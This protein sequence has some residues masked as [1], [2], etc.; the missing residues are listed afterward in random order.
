MSRQ[1]LP[2]HGHLLHRANGHDPIPVLLHVRV[3]SDGAGVSAGD[4]KRTITIT[5]DLGGTR[6][7]SAQA[8][9]V[10]GGS[11][12]TTIQIHNVTEAVDMLADKIQIDSGDTD[13]YESVAPSVVDDT[14]TP[15]K[16]LVSRGDKIRVDVDA[17]GTGAKGLEVLL[18]FG[19]NIVRLTPAP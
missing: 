17:A 7:R 3:T 18:E 16:N 11:T 19:P 14:G 6:L 10:T 1:V 8:T 12:A 4:G 9:L 15:P 13:S 2:L 5:D